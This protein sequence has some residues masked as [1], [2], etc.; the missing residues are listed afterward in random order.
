MTEQQTTTLTVP[1]TDRDHVQGLAS[2]AVTLV[3][4]GD[5]E[6]PDCAAV[7]PMVELL[8]KQQGERLRFVF[9]HFPL[10][11]LHPHAESAAEAAEAAGAQNQF[12]EMHE[13]LLANQDALGSS[14]LAEY[15]GQLGIESTWFDEV[16]AAR[17]FEKRV[18][19]DFT[20]GVRSGV[21]GTPT[22]F[23]NGVRHDGALSLASLT[24]A[25][26]A[27]AKHKDRA[28]RKGHR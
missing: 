4:Y 6:C 25:V 15:A 19:E 17:T 9:R 27:S 3:E 21:N 18:R 8:R 22:F 16:M 7:V 2:A 11:D 23:V 26:D 28:F 5:F 12:W 1:V 20:S 14:N 13:T 10:K 24:D